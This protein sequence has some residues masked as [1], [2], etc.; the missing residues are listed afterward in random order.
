[1]SNTFEVFRYSSVVFFMSGATEFIP[2]KKPTPNIIITMID[3]YLKIL[4]F[5]FRIESL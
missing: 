3:I 4:V 5:S 1:M 2:T